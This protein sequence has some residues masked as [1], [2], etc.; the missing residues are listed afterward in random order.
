MFVDS[1]WV[2][3]W[4]QETD[5]P[6][7]DLYLGGINGDPYSQTMQRCCIARHGRGGLKIHSVNITKPLP[8]ATVNIGFYDGHVEGVQDENL[9]TLIWHYGWQTP[10]PRPAE[11]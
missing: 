3:L 5:M 4:P 7:A 6:P 2:D 11:H 10:S 1:I 9:W 8:I